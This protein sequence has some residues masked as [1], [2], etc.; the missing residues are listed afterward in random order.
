MFAGLLILCLSLS[1]SARSQIVSY[2]DETAYLHALEL[3]GYIASHESFEDDAAWGDL[4]SSRTAPSN[5]NLGITWSSSS[6]NN[7]ITTGQGPARTGTWGFF[8]LPHGDYENGIGDG[9]SGTGNRPLVAIGGWLST[10][11]PTAKVSLFLDGDELNSADF[12]DN[13]FLGS[14]SRFFGVIHPDGFSRFDFRELEGK[15]ENQKFIFADDFTFAFGG[16]LQDCNGNGIA[17]SLDIADKTSSD[18]NQNHVPD[19]CEILQDCNSNGIL[20]ECELL[21]PQGYASGELSPIGD[22]SPQSFTI[23]APPISRADVILRFTARANLGGPDEYIDVDINGI[24]VGT[25]FGPDGNDCPELGPDLAQIIVP[26]DVFNDSSSEGNA[27]INLKASTAVAPDECDLP[28]YVTVEVVLFVPSD[29]DVNENGILDQCEKD[30]FLRGDANADGAS[31]ISDAVKI[32]FHLFLGGGVSC[33]DAMDV[34][35]SGE[36]DITDVLFLLRYLF[37]SGQAP[38]PPF[39]TCGPD[40]TE[41]AFPP[42][43]YPAGSCG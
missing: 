19:E 5:V 37:Q 40:G 20:D 14:Q 24:P 4:R 12:G 33:A 36:T 2:T 13:A 8:S 21:S 6:E 10:N 25:V 1:A 11:T 42:C 7:G 3:R 23:Q 32:L 34:D 41:D 16:S 38:P 27:V 29:S 18:C 22:G 15:L 9:F 31:D 39:F 43:E 30:Q 26:V 35:D 17:D 28:S